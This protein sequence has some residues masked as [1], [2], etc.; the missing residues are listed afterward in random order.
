MRPQART[1]SAKEGADLQELKF[2]PLN[3]ATALE[4]APSI[5]RSEGMCS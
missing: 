3:L 1:S 2:R 4:I 5:Y